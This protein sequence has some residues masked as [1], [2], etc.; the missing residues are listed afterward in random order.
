M[1]AVS[2]MNTDLTLKVKVNGITSRRTV[3]E[4]DLQIISQNIKANTHMMI[5]SATLLKC[6]Q[7][8]LT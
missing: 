8:I 1:N 6:Q 5:H 2:L 4:Q 3:T 7:G